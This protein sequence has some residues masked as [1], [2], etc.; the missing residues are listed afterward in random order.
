MLGPRD[1][2]Q[3]DERRHAFVAGNPHQIV[4]DLP[5]QLDVE[6]G[7]RL[8]G[9]KDPRL[10]RQRARNRDAL[11]LAAGEAVGALAARGAAG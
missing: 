1:V 5:G 10:L 3:A 11:L 2:V 7:D 4:H 8:V 6:A 9:E